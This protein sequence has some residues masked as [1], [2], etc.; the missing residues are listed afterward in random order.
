MRRMLDPKEAGG[1]LPSTI[2]FDE[3]GNRTVGKNLGVDG[4]LTLKSLVSNTNPDGDI[5]KEL[6]GGEGAINLHCYDVKIKN[7]NNEIYM[8]F[9]TTKLLKGFVNPG[10]TQTNK[11]MYQ[12]KEFFPEKNINIPCSGSA[13]QGTNEYYPVVA[14]RLD[15]NSYGAIGG[16]FPLICTGTGGTTTEGAIIASNNLLQITRRY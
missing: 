5:T 14:I 15:P 7:S 12:Y 16:R 6:G 4:K 10:D 8:S 2:K 11:S 1:S 13:L 3:E 9:Y